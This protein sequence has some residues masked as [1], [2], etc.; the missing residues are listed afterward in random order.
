MLDW[1]P[2]FLGSV[3]G[4]IGRGI[5]DAIGWTVSAIAGLFGTITNDV[6]DA[7]HDLAGDV[8]AV[9][10]GARLLGREFFRNINRIV[11]WWLP[12]FAVT[13]WW[14]VTHPDDLASVLFWHLVKWLE[15]RA[16]E[17]GRYLGNFALALIT[18]NVGR[19]AR[20]AEEIITAVL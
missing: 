14:W 2:R 13:A 3:G 18:R 19:V 7:W 1:L 11:N 8:L 16:W 10:E 9:A 5:S 6:A 20:L 17:A 15:S 12:R 4:L